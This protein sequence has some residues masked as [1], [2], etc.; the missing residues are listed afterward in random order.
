MST[1]LIEAFKV[2]TG[3]ER[4]AAEGW[5]RVTQILSDRIPKS[6]HTFAERQRWFKHELAASEQSSEFSDFLNGMMRR[7]DSSISIKLVRLARNGFVDPDDFYAKMAE[8][9]RAW[10]GI[11]TVEVDPLSDPDYVG[12]CFRPIRT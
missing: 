1:F 5:E 7:G 3:L 10:A 6:L 8:L 12:V 2:K 9:N 4:Q 11:V